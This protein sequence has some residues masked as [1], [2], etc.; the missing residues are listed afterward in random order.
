MWPAG[1][2]QWAA[3]AS[4]TANTTILSAELLPSGPLK[5]AG[6]AITGNCLVKGE[7][8]DVPSSWSPDRSRPLCPYPEVARLM[9]ATNLETAD[10]FAC[11]GP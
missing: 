5:W 1:A 8:R 10:S 7:V 3:V 2:R 9:E 4:T 6:R 11:G